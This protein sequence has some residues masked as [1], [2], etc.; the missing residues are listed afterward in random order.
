MEIWRFIFVS[1][2]GFSALVKH[3][4]LKGRRYMKTALNGKGSWKCIHVQKKSS[5][6]GRDIRI[7]SS[8]TNVGSQE[9]NV[10]KRMD[11]KRRHDNYFLR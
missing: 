10:V 5:N 7:T 6:R 9:S 8:G 3:S 11:V 2:S 4:V 1:V